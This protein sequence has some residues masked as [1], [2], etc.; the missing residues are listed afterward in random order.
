MLLIFKLINYIRIPYGNVS[1]FDIY[2]SFTRNKYFYIEL[3]LQNINFIFYNDDNYYLLLLI[4]YFKIKHN[5]SFFFKYN[6]KYLRF[7]IIKNVLFNVFFF[8][9]VYILYN[10]LV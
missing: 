8:F 1:F 3:L 2:T 7:Y 5:L 6:L 10:Y 4:I 9:N